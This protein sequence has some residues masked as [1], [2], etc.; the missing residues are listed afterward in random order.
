MLEHGYR[1]DRTSAFC[2]CSF[3]KT[4]LIALKITWKLDTIER[5]NWT[6]SLV[7]ENL[8]IYIEL[9]VNPT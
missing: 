3:A 1:R 4:E 2:D 9:N 7:I 6:D 8:K 5:T